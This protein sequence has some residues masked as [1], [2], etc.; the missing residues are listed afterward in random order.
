VDKLDKMYYAIQDEIQNHDDDP[1]WIKGVF[2]DF[3]GKTQE[4]EDRILA[5][6]VD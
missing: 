2:K 4:D 1:E 3:F 5:N 6:I